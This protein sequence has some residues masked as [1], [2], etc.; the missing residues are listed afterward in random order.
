MQSTFHNTFLRFRPTVPEGV[1]CT[2]IANSV[3][4]KT[5]YLYVLYKYNYIYKT[6]FQCCAKDLCLANKHNSFLKIW[7]K[8]LYPSK[9]FFALSLKLFVFPV[10]I[11]KSAIIIKRQNLLVCNSSKDR[12]LLAKVNSKWYDLLSIKHL[13]VKWRITRWCFISVSFC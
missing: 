6:H 4:F 10:F 1:I 11:L 5:I 7:L 13:L 3:K 2:D 9:T 12:C 8:V